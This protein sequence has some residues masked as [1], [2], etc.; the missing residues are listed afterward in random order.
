MFEFVVFV[1]N[2]YYIQVLRKKLL[3]NAP[4]THII[5]DFVNVKVATVNE[6]AS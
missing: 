5:K 3:V 1:T 6:T 2:Y 4:A